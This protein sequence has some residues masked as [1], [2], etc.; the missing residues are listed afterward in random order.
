MRNQP[1]DYVSE[2]SENPRKEVVNQT[3][4]QILVNWIVLTLGLGGVAALGAILPELL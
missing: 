2:P 1:K 3:G 4:L